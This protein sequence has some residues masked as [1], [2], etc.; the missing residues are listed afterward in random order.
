[1]FGWQMNTW[2]PR[3]RGL[4]RAALTS[5]LVTLTVGCASAPVSVELTASQPVIV[6]V[7]AGPDVEREYCTGDVVRPD[8][9]LECDT[10]T[11]PWECYARRKPEVREP[12]VI[13][14]LADLSGK[15][16]ESHPLVFTF[17]AEDPRERVYYGDVEF[18]MTD[19]HGSE[20]PRVIRK[21]IELP[22][23][24]YAARVA[25]SGTDER[26]ELV[27]QPG[28]S[29]ASC[30]G[31]RFGILSKTGADMLALPA[32]Q[33]LSK[34]EYVF[35]LD[36]SEGG[37]LSGLLAVRNTS[38]PIVR[39]STISVL[40][41]MSPEDI[42]AVREGRTQVKLYQTFPTSTGADASDQEADDHDILAEVYLGNRLSCAR[43]RLDENEQQTIEVRFP[44]GLEV[45]LW[46]GEALRW[47][48]G[49]AGAPGGGQSPGGGQH[50]I[51][52]VNTAQ[53]AEGDRPYVRCRQ[54]GGTDF[55]Y[56]MF[57]VPPSVPDSAMITC[58]PVELSGDDVPRILSEGAVTNFRST[59]AAPETPDTKTEIYKLTVGRRKPQVITRL[60]KGNTSAGQE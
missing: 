45:E 34:G 28:G 56:G 7:S 55:I 14:P 22:F 27:L 19:L 51:L 37:R 23:Q 42:A 39:F 50:L 40:Q 31:Y 59:Y 26:M 24:R 9:P 10:L 35:E 54:P 8:D 5:A 16:S 47:R 25:A 52:P 4:R 38:D 41:S 46:D 2:V 30:A 13:T 15:V 6:Y 18:A 32:T 53:I 48:P 3:R 60:E 57:H 21:H 11:I 49:T 20:V 33:I 1:M 44:V 12:D 58:F 29:D 17:R 36:V 43:V